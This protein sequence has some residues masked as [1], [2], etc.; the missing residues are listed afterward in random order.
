VALT[1]FSNQHTEYLKKRIERLGGV[2]APE[3][4]P[5]TEEIDCCIANSSN[6]VISVKK[7][8]AAALGI[9]LTDASSILDMGRLPRWKPASPPAHRFAGKRFCLSEKLSV[10]VGGESIYQTAA[11]EPSG[12][13]TFLQSSL[14]LHEFSGV[15]DFVNKRQIAVV[16]IVG[17]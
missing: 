9:T 3:N 1:G 16:F 11:P 5:I 15:F 10:S 6:S 12:S 13:R 2:V 14:D 8:T 7:F 17:R 4:Q